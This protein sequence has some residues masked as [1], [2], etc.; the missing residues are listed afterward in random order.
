MHPIALQLGH[1]IAAE[2]MFNEM[3]KPGP[4]RRCPK[5]SRKHRIKNKDLTDAGFLAKDKYVKLLKAQRA[6]TLAMLE[7][8]P[9][10]DLDDNR[11]GKL[12]T[13]SADRRGR[14]AIWPACIR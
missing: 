12:P 13:L 4:P 10:S 5:D 6:A 8:V 11:D 3:V 14:V 1:L 7:A 9:E 2:R